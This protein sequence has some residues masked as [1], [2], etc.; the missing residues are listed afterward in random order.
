MSS[1]RSLACRR[2]FAKASGAARRGDSTVDSVQGVPQHD[3]AAGGEESTRP[4]QHSRQTVNHFTI[5][6][7]EPMPTLERITQ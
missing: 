4:I 6:W 1:D 7:P 3:F 5:L 2:D